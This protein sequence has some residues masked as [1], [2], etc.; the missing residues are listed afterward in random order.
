MKISNSRPKHQPVM[1]GQQVLE[2]LEKEVLIKRKSLLD[3][4][5][6]L[7]D[8]GGTIEDRKTNSSNNRFYRLDNK[9]IFGETTVSDYGD[10]ERCKR[11]YGVGRWCCSRIKTIMY[12]LLV[13]IFVDTRMQ[14]EARSSDSKPRFQDPSLKTL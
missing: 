13:V 7:E 2:P 3:L 9:V 8:R 12:L 14:A 5:S 10:R 6:L 4:K 11:R 1:M